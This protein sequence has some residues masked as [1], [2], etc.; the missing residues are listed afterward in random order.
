MLASRLQPVRNGSSTRETK[1]TCTHID[2]NHWGNYSNSNS[3]PDP[4]S[5]SYSE[6]NQLTWSKAL[7]F[8]DSVGEMIFKFSL[9]NDEQRRQVALSHVVC[10]QCKRHLPQGRPLVAIGLDCRICRGEQRERAKVEIKYTKFPSSLYST[11]RIY[12]CISPG[13]GSRNLS[14]RLVG[15]QVDQDSSPGFLCLLPGQQQVAPALA[16]ALASLS[17]AHLPDAP[18][19]KRHGDCLVSSIG[20]W[21]E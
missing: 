1:Y 8:R 10:V 12:I 14:G 18:K 7:L 11:R 5:N 16:F 21:S 19:D 15:D 20:V 6:S 9:R 2:S 3:N 13:H 4:N 17:E